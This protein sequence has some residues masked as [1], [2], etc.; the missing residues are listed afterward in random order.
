VH[1]R[2]EEVVQ[3]VEADSSDEEGEG[4]RRFRKRRVFTSRKE[5]RWVL[6]DKRRRNVLHG[7]VEGQTARYF[8]II[9]PKEGTEQPFQIVPVHQWL[10]F[11]KPPNFKPLSASEAKVMQESRS[12]MTK[13]V[14]YMEARQ[15]KLDDDLEAEGG[16]DNT[17]GMA[18]A[19][20]RRRLRAAQAEEGKV[21]LDMENPDELLQS[22]DDRET[23][24]QVS[25]KGH[26]GRVAV[27]EEDL[28]NSDDE[29]DIE[30]LAIDRKGRGRGEGNGDAD[31][32]NNFEDDEDDGAVLEEEEL[33][34]MNE[35]TLITG[36]E[37]LNEA[38]SDSGSEE[39]E[40]DEEEDEDEEEEEDQGAA[41]QQSGAAG[42]AFQPR[43]KVVE[44]GTGGQASDAAS[45]E[46]GD[47]AGVAVPSA[48]ANGKRPAEASS[49]SGAP[50]RKRVKSPLQMF[51]DS[52]IEAVRH[53]GGVM[54]V[55]K[56][57]K[58]VTNKNALKAIGL[59]KK[60]AK[61]ALTGIVK[62]N[63]DI[64]EDTI[65]GSMHATLKQELV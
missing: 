6:S 47:G 64:S 23:K 48:A 35:D 33:R 10:E 22:D 14:S 26:G 3:E 52:V 29:E 1:L 55:Q 41:S 54:D 50:P 20:K 59:S 27:M 43:I 13:I 37:E 44:E 24:A 7:T 4:A 25:S 42:V 16:I 5:T 57:F 8:C 32:E 46:A 19:K 45:G 2:E 63:F 51:K 9:P 12:S 40:E 56:L 39:D 58:Q 21:D 53:S 28:D 30:V 15:R 65:T 11:K 60:E 61:T 34:N 31:F 38:L 18:G 36:A 49:S 62:E 17:R